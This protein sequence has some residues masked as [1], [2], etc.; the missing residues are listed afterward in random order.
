LAPVSFSIKNANNEGDFF[1]GIAPTCSAADD[2][3]HQLGDVGEGS[4]AEALTY[5]RTGAC[6]PRAEGESRRLRRA[7]DGRP[8][9]SAWQALLNAW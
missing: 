6:S 4:F 3:S 8:R 5:L 1:S 2:S 7:G 9:V